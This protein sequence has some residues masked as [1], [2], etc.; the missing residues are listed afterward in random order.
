MNEKYQAAQRVFGKYAEDYMHKYADTSAYQDGIDAFCRYM[1]VEEPKILD[2]GCGPGLQALDLA[3]KLPQMKYTGI[4]ASKEMLTLAKK[5]IPNGEFQQMDALNIDELEDTYDGIFVSFCLPYMS[6][7]EVAEFIAKCRLKLKSG[8]ALYLSCMMGDENH[9]GWQEKNG[10][11]LYSSY[12]CA[13]YLASKLVE[14]SFTNILI[15]RM[16]SP[17]PSPESNTD[18]IIVANK[19]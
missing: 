8:G 6:Y 5:N 7:E 12:F 4:D 11:R 16:L 17:N 3:E 14:N 15:D 18:L 9:S 13:S 2:V 10:D 1:S 19:N